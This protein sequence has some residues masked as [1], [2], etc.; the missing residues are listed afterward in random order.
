M[1]NLLLLILIILAG[2]SYGQDRPVAVWELMEVHSDTIYTITR[3]EHYSVNQ[4]IDKLL[5]MYEAYELEC[6]TNNFYCNLTLDGFINYLKHLKEPE[7]EIDSWSINERNEIRIR[8]R[9]AY[10][11]D[12]VRM[13]KDDF[14]ISD[15]EKD[16]LFTHNYKRI[17]MEYLKKR[18]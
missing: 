16:S 9:K 10:G 2:Y 18:K 14:I 6:Y 12:T 5:E 13:F 11:S 17:L 7:I 1:K 8:Y 3:P 4:T 15:K